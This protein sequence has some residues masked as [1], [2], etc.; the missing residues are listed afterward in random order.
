M[1][2]MNTRSNPANPDTEL[3]VITQAHSIGIDDTQ[4]LLMEYQLKLDIDSTPLA[5]I[6]LMA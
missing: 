5:Y 4:T 3:V 1:L 2:L 6:K